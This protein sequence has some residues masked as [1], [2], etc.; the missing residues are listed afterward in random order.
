[1]GESD[2]GEERV[3]AELSVKLGIRVSLRTAP[4]YWPYDAD[5]KVRR[6]TS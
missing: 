1:M 6:R 4:A 3:V 5:S 2:L